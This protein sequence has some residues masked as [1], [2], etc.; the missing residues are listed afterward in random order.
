MCSRSISR[1][2]NVE[3]N[4]STAAQCALLLRLQQQ[5]ESLVFKHVSV[6]LSEDGRLFCTGV[7]DFRPCMSLSPRLSFRVYNSLAWWKSEIVLMERVYEDELFLEK[8][9]HPVQVVQ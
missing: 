7:R 6:S 1:S 8:E 5:F 2:F 3:S 9:G 4:I